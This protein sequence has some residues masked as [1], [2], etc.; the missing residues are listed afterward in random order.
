M[1]RQVVKNQITDEKSI[2]EILPDN[3]ELLEDFIDYLRSVDRSENTIYQYRADLNIFFVYNLKFNGNKK[4]IEITKRELTKFQNYALTEWGWSPKRLRRVKSVISSLSNFIENIL[5]EEEEFKDFRSIVNKIESPAN[6]PTLEKSIF[7]EW[8]LKRLLDDLVEKKK[9]RQAAMLALAMYSGRRKAELPR[10][11]VS[12][13][14]DENIIFGKLW[15]THEKVRTKGRGSKGKLVHLYVMKD[16]FEPYLKLWM[17]YRE[18]NGIESEWLFPSYA[19]FSRPMSLDTMD[20]WARHFTKLLGKNFYWHSM[21]HY[22][23]T[24]LAK[25]DVPVSVIQDIVSWESPDMVKLYTDISAD[26][27]IGR[28]FASNG[29]ELRLVKNAI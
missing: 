8:E 20:D 13:F 22:F 19:D 15:K 16:G 26:E 1:A 10:F 23:T 21:R 27:N 18:E 9:Y 5:D 2:A 29:A 17:R 7:S 28:W 12:Y 11:K 25:N 3:K 6:V 24:M 14:A 4:F